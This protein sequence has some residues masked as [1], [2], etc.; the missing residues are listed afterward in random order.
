MTVCVI[1]KLFIILYIAIICSIVIKYTIYSI[2]NKCTIYWKDLD[3]GK[4]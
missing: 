4:Y 1:I 2:L 3:A